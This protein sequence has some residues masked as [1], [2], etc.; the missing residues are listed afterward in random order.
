MQR[1]RIRMRY[2]AADDKR[3]SAVPGVRILDAGHRLISAARTAVNIAIRACAAV[4]LHRVFAGVFG[5]HCGGLPG[6]RAVLHRAESGFRAHIGLDKI[7][8]VRQCEGNVVIASR[9][10]EG[11]HLLI[12]SREGAEILEEMPLIGFLLRESEAEL[13]IAVLLRIIEAAVH[14]EI[15]HGA[16]VFVVRVRTL[17]PALDVNIHGFVGRVFLGVINHLAHNRVPPL[18]LLD[19]SYIMISGS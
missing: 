9:T 16:A 7:G 10:L 6:D 14:E 1:Y 8:A 13:D 4:E 5:A 12:R 11:G 2:R 15:L 3:R 18:K 17:F 19:Y